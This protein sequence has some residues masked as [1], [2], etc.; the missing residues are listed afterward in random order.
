MKLW[1][2]IYCPDCDAKNWIYIGE[3]NDITREDIDAVQCWSC[4]KLFWVD[5]EDVEDEDELEMR[6]P[7]E[8]AYI[9]E[10]REI[11]E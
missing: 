5:Q 6:G 3:E 8:D 11:P 9:E 10:G 2:E 4:S 7:I 1:A